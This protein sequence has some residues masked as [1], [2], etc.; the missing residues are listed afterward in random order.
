[1]S[2]T[3]KLK[4]HWR[5]NN[6]SGEGYEYYTLWFMHRTIFGREKWKQLKYYTGISF[7]GYTGDRKWA[8]KI[9]AHYG[10]KIPGEPSLKSNTGE[11][12]E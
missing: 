10:I 1:M 5:F 6:Y 12:T 4:R 11:K 8:E 9:A 3:V 7:S 2:D